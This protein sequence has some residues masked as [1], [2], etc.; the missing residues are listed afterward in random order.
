VAG[1]QPLKNNKKFT[2]FVHFSIDFEL[3]CFVCDQIVAFIMQLLNFFSLRLKLS[4]EVFLDDLC[5]IIF[6]ILLVLVEFELLLDNGL[7]KLL[8]ETL[9]QVEFILENSQTEKN[10]SAFELALTELEFSNLAYF[11]QNWL[12]DSFKLR[13]KSH[14][15]QSSIHRER[16]LIQGLFLSLLIFICINHIIDFSDLISRCQF[17]AVSLVIDNNFSA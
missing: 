16:A 14:E 3:S 10:L 11:L 12:N 15:L 6:L 5:S 8:S 13:I 9:D 7:D 17:R 2:F 4:F 1:P